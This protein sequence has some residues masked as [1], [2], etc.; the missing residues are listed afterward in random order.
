MYTIGATE[1]RRTVLL[2]GALASGSQLTGLAELL[3][4]ACVLPDLPGHGASVSAAPYA[5]ADFVDT[6]REALG[7][8]GD[9]VGYSLGGYVALATALAHPTLVRRV[10]TV[11]TKLA[12]TPEVASAEAGRLDVGRLEAKAPSFV[13]GLSALHPGSSG[14]SVLE[15]TAAFLLG[16]GSAP[17]LELERIAC[18]VLVV[19]GEDDAMVTRGECEEAVSRLPDGRLAVLP[20]AP[21]AYERMDVAA[22]AAVVAPFLA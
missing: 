7:D 9:L 21:H 20:G 12:W 11:A 19:V 4:G 18:P 5:L 1:L 10:V 14:R 8:G 15:R 16:L 22:L 2:H 6:A 3:D 13:E 17:P